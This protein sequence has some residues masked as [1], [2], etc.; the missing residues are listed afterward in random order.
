MM[1]IYMEGSGCVRRSQEGRSIIFYLFPVVLVYSEPGVKVDQAQLHKKT[2]IPSGKRNESPGAS[3]QPRKL[4]LAHAL[5]TGGVCI[6]YV[7][8]AFL[9][10]WFKRKQLKIKSYVLFS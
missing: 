5:V 1:T 9:H 7:F 8:A 6:L 3:R 2:K 4:F 10:M